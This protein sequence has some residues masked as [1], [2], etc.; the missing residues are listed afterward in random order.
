[1][2]FY[3]LLTQ[4]TV[5]GALVA[6]SSP[7][8]AEGDVLKGERVFRKCGSCHSVKDTSNRVGPHLIGIV[9]RQIASVPEFKYSEDLKTYATT[10]LTW[11]EAK[12]DA[13]FENP[14]ALVAKTSMVFSGIKKENERQD[15]IAYLKTIQ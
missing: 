15:L 7:S 3:T 9:G 8:F 5:L 4:W 6:S 10:A 11:D 14:K 13:Y 12:L 2:N 1:M